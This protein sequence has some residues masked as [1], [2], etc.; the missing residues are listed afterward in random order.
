VVSPPLRQPCDMEWPP[1]SAHNLLRHPVVS[2]KMRVTF[3][4]HP[5]MY[6]VAWA[7][8]LA[9]GS[10][11]LPLCTSVPSPVIP[12]CHLCNARMPRPPPPT[13]AW[14]VFRPAMLLRWGKHMQPSEACWT[15]SLCSCLPAKHL[16]WENQETLHSAGW[17]LGP[18]MSQA[19]K[20]GT[21]QNVER[22]LSV[23]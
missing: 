7:S 14:A 10:M 3:R 21:V 8:D 4:H 12:F 18:Q 1:S 11:D 6:L 2:R 22:W 19:Q 5:T 17:V 13:S 15:K 16:C 23:S 9:W 20:R